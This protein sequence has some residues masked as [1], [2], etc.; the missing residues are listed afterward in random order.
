MEEVFSHNADQHF[1]PASVMKD[2]LCVALQE[3]GRDVDLDRDS[4]HS[5]ITNEG[6]LKEIKS[7]V[8]D[9]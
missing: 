9:P 7:L 5:E 8:C 4:V 3:L 1:I 2:S 6:V